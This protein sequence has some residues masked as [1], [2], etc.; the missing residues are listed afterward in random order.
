[1]FHLFQA[2]DLLANILI[3]LLHL[4]LNVLPD[5]FKSFGCAMVAEIGDSTVPFY[6][7]LALP[8]WIHSKSSAIIVFI[9][10]SNPGRDELQLIHF[11][12]LVKLL[13]AFGEGIVRSELVYISKHCLLLFGK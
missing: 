1:L 12:D 9:K 6:L 7:L 3:Q 2:S 11:D 8:H 13:F 10:N 4:G 5:L